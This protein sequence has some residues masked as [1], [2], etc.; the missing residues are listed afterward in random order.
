MSPVSLGL[1]MVLHDHF[2]HSCE[3][4]IKLHQRSW[5]KSQ[6]MFP[7]GHKIVATVKLDGKDQF[8]QGK[9]TP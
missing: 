4:S 2:V 8:E 3:L 7:F 6:T 5:V 9:S 1:S